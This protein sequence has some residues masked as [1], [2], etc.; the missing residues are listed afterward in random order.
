MQRSA[1]RGTVAAGNRL[2][3]AGNLLF[4]AEILGNAGIEPEVVGVLEGVV[5][6]SSA[7]SMAAVGGREREIHDR[8]IENA[9]RAVGARAVRGAPRTRAA[10]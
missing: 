2:S 9:R 7:M 6:R 3:I 4:M 10:R 5:T 1:V 8:A